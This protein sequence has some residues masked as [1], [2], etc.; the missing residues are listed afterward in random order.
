MP[1]LPA[2]GWA[3]DADLA[4]P[5]ILIGLTF[6]LIPVGT[7]TV[8]QRTAAADW[9]RPDLHAYGRGL[10]AEG[11]TPILASFLNAIPHSARGGAA[12]LAV[13]QGSASRFLRYWVAALFV[14]K[15]FCS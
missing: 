2:F 13:T 8:A 3:F 12:C 6:S 7:Q 11:L 14:T 10:R 5:Y 1:T 9:H 4:L 15:R